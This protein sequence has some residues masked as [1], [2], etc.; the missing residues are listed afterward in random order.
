MSAEAI[1]IFDLPYEETRRLLAGGAPVFLS[2]NPV[3]YHGP[4]LPMRNDAL[5]SAGLLRDLHARLE[6]DEPGLPLLHAGEIA[7]GVDP[8]PGP[9]SQFARFSDSC[10]LVRTACT[11][12]ANIGARRVVLMTFHGAPLH[13]L[14]LEEGVKLLAGRGVRALS[15]LNGML[16]ALMTVPLDQFDEAIATVDDAAMRKRLSEEMRYDF[17]AGFGET[18][19][20]LHYAP[21]SVS[22][23]YR[24]L[25]PCPSYQPDRRLLFASRVAARLGRTELATEL[26]FAAHGAAWQSLK[27]HPGYTGSPAQASAAAGTAL[28][29]L[30]IDG[31]AELAREVFAGRAN[32]PPPILRW[33]ARATLGGRLQPV[34]AAG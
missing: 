31:Y 21:A 25:P 29:R 1:P 14:A 19:L 32:S 30:I 18:S 24:T 6:A 4:H 17:H 13:N 8:A 10:R 3:E 27:P 26:R 5:V 22:P 7:I 20:T 23:S 16:R 15:P 12:L 2:I 11:S 9:G 34:P 33:I 28:A